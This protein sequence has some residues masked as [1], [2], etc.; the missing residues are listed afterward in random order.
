MNQSMESSIA[1]KWIKFDEVLFAQE[2]I[3]FD[4]VLSGKNEPYVEKYQI[5]GMN[6]VLGSIKL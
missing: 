4:E 2:W 3:N 6:Q 5:K 1:G